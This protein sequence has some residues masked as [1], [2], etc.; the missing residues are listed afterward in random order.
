MTPVF[1]IVFRCD[2]GQ[3]E[4]CERIPTDPGGFA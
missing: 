2:P 3:P 4:M 1:L